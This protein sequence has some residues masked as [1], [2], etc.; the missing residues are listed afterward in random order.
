MHH[1]STVTVREPLLL[2]GRA[3]NPDTG[4]GY[5]DLELTGK[6]A[7]PPRRRARAR[8]RAHAA[9]GSSAIYPDIGLALFYLYI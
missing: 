2:A 3:V 5:A 1:W 7:T 9:D 4:I 6:G 8:P